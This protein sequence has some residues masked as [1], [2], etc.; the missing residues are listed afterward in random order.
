MTN[1]RF[2]PTP[3]GNLHLGHLYLILLN[4]H[5]AK[6]NNGKFIVRFDDE[7]G[8][9][10]TLGIDKINRFCEEIKEDLS[11]M[12]IEPD[13]YSYESKEKE[14]NERYLKQINIDVEEL[15]KPL[16]DLKNRERDGIYPQIKNIERP[17]PYVP[18]L[19]A[20]KVVQ[21]YRE[22]CGILI[23]GDDLVSEFSLYCHLCKILN[24]PIPKFYFVPKLMQYKKEGS[25]DSLSDL[26]DVSKTEGNF[27]LRDLRKKGYSPKEIIEWLGNLCL[28][29]KKKGWDYENI[30][31][32][33]TIYL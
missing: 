7:E 17:H 6:E 21:D 4:Y 15:K 23:R 19:T 22:G 32:R 9:V 20:V 3:N 24:I 10:E 13:L 5:T 11:W 30:K 25:E 28:I 29:D 31:Q 12:G 18:Y 14:E 33:P 27:K 2:N 8:L 26:T 1:T 16:K